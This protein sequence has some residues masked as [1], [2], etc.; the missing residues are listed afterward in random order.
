M[1]VRILIERW[2]EMK[3]GAVKWVNNCKEKN[4]CV[5][6]GTSLEGEKKIVRGCHERCHAATMRAIRRGEFTQDERVAEGKLLERENGGRPR[7]N[8][9]SIEAAG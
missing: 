1:C 2:V 4:L 7:S 6:C 9:V 8:P 5:A 3:K